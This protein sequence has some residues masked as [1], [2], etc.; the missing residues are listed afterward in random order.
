VNNNEFINIVTKRTNFKRR[1]VEFVLQTCFDVICESLRQNEDVKFFGFGKFYVKS[2]KE[3]AFYNN[4]CNRT[5]LVKGKS[6]PR[7]KTYKKFGEIIK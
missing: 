7:F 1:E 4:F 5:I 6:V 2:S 3:R